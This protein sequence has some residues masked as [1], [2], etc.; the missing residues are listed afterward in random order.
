M[1]LLL[2]LLVFESPDLL[3]SDWPTKNVNYN[4]LVAGPIH[5]RAQHGSINLG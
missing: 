2:C 1:L 3:F 4:S 5:H